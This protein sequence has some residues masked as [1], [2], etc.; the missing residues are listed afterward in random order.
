[1]LWEFNP[2]FR[3]LFIQLF[4]QNLTKIPGRFSQFKTD[5][6]KERLHDSVKHFG[7]CCRPC[8]LA[9]DFSGLF[10]T[11]LFWSR[12]RFYSIAPSLLI[13]FVQVHSHVEN[14]YTFVYLLRYHF[15]LWLGGISARKLTLHQRRPPLYSHQLNWIQGTKRAVTILANTKCYVHHKCLLHKQ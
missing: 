2:E 4:N 8:S 11:E 14:I 5:P 13:R 9:P 1:M 15:C 12:E 3:A 6:V 7:C 10:L